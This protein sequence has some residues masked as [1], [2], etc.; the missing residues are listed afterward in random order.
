MSKETFLKNQEG[1]LTYKKIHGVKAGHTL[2]VQFF[3]FFLI[4]L[5]MK[6]G[7]LHFFH[8]LFIHVNQSIEGNSLQVR[9][10][11]FSCAPAPSLYLPYF[12]HCY[13]GP[14]SFP[15]GRV[16]PRPRLPSPSPVAAPVTS[17]LVLH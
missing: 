16:G 4:D 15:M 2:R 5:N 8:T 1:G 13:I 11:G 7:C 17:S 9:L 12:L 14:L 10:Q 6:P 3:F